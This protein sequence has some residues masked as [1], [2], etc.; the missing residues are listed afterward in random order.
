MKT[1]KALFSELMYDFQSERWNEFELPKLSLRELLAL[2]KLLGCPS[3]GSKETVI[4]RLLA[5]RELRLKLARFTDNQLRS[6]QFPINV[7]RSRRGNYLA[8]RI[9]KDSRT[10]G[11]TGSPQSRNREATGC[12]KCFEKSY[13][14]A[15]AA[16]IEPPWISRLR[17]GWN[18]VDMFPGAGRQ[19]T[20]ESMTGTTWL[21][22]QPALI[23]RE[24]EG[25]SRKAM[26]P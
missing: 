17:Q 22:S 16:P 25:T 13:R 24:P 5:Q 6:W 11:L 4:V 20:G 18:T 10:E 26:A 8:S 9:P 15:K 21:S 3:C 2:A 23:P 1:T 12:S 19:R 14:V 7:N